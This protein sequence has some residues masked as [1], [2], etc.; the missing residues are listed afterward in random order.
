MRPLSRFGAEQDATGRIPSDFHC[1]AI[2]V[3]ES[4]LFWTH[5]ELAIVIDSDFGDFVFDHDLG[6]HQKV[7]HTTSASFGSK[8]RDPRT[9]TSS[10]NLRHPAGFQAIEEWRLWEK[11][12][13]VFACRNRAV[14]DPN[15]VV[16]R[17]QSASA[18]S[19][20]RPL[21]EVEEPI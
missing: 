2:D 18:E 11:A 16:A 5:I 6:T 12:D 15:R 20:Y 10:W 19:W 4:L 9:Q 7:I 8:A 21:T 3:G 1:R 14:R 13:L 17:R